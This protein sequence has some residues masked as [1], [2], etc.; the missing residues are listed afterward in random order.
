M[1]W[2]FVNDMVNSENSSYTVHLELKLSELGFLYG[3][4]YVYDFKI[5][6]ISLI[7][8]ILFVGDF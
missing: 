4:D 5:V 7:K 2:K 1:T 8:F 6:I 3:L